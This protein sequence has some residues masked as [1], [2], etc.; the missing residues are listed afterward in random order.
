MELSSWLHGIHIY[1][2]KVYL[3]T[4]YDKILGYLWGE[5]GN[6]TLKVHWPEHETYSA[7]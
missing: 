2:D 6:V 4:S 5:N 7:M 3:V 1:I